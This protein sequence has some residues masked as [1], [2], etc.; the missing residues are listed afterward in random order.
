MP[1][2]APASLLRPAA[3]VL[4]S[5]T[6]RVIG[7]FPMSGLALLL[8]GLGATPLPLAL[9]SLTAGAAMLLLGALCALARG[10]QT[11][12]HARDLA[13]L[14]RL[15]GESPTPC[16]LCDARGQVQWA[17]AAARTAFPGASAQGCTAILSLQSADPGA[18]VQRLHDQALARGSATHHEPGP[19]PLGVRVECIT[20]QLFLW[21]LESRLPDDAQGRAPL[22]LIEFAAD[23]TVCHV[24]PG[25]RDQIGDPP[26]GLDALFSG[27][28]PP[29]GLPCRVWLGQ[30]PFT[31]LRLSRPETGTSCAERVLLL[32][33]HAHGDIPDQDDLADPR[34]TLQDL[35]IA[36]AH[37]CAEGQICHANTEARRLLRLGDGPLPLL[38]D[39]LEGL[40]R[41]VTEWLADIATGRLAP[42]TEVLRLNRSDCE[43]FLK[44]TLAMAAPGNGRERQIIAVFHDVTELKSLEAKF[45]QSQKMQAIGQ[46]AGGV[47]HDFNNLLTAIS[48]H[49]DL[50]LLRHDRSDLDYP[51]LM[52]I[53]QN[54]NRAAAL[55]RQLLALSRQ[56]TLKFETLDLEEIMGDVIHLLNR[57]VG[58]R[59]TLTLHH[60]EAL[61]PIRSDRRQ[62]EQVLMNLVVNARDAMPMGGEIRIRT[63]TLDLAQGLARDEVNL[64]PG[65]YTRVRVSDDGVGIPTQNLTKVFDPFFTSKRQGEGTGLGLS[66]VYGIVK[67]SGGYIFVDSEEGVGS[68]FTLYFAAQKHEAAAPPEPLPS[69]QSSPLLE[70]RALVLLVEDEAAVRS[71]AARALELQGHRVIEA[72]CGEAALEILSNPAIRPDFFVTDVVMPGIDGPGWIARI[73]DRFPD[74]PVL[75]MSGYAADRRVAA[76]AR[77]SNATFLGKPFSLAEFTNLVNDQLRART[78]AA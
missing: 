57:L 37:V 68:T 4:A 5:V 69:L 43:T 2:I 70:R 48:G 40:G 11:W 65:R 67:Q 60:G 6:W 50:I 77:I 14:A 74:T 27:R 3:D 66:T 39:T 61:A 12:L 73:R 8:L 55:V 41:P 46:L 36:I 23:G 64:P 34:A 44:V 21:R 1:Q 59:I 7:L 31:A 10:M 29:A 22:P 9:A 18:R 62:F 42:S 78:R 45:T 15:H 53:Q 47:A 28:I 35:P 13:V 30:A 32:R 24:A 56:Q 17:N 26:P 20:P 33:Q 38:S 72:D 52:Q 54:T 75:F 16:L 76:Q 51:D 19:S 71:F 49:C 58:E 63:D 25:L